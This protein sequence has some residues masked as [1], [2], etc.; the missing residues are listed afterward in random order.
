MDDK[1][2]DNSEGLGTDRYVPRG[3]CTRKSAVNYA[4]RAR[5]ARLVRVLNEG[6]FA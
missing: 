4:V 1:S 3:S 6:R 5:V 2:E